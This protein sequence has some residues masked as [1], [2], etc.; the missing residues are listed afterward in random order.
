MR[1]KVL[2]RQ[3]SIILYGITPAYAGKSLAAVL[4]GFQYRDHPRLCG[5]KSAMKAYFDLAEGSPPPMRGKD[6]ITSALQIVC[7]ITPAYAGKS[8][9]VTK[10][11]TGDLGSPP[12]MRGKVNFLSQHQCF[13]QDHPR[14]CGEKCTQKSLILYVI[15]S[16]PP[17]RGKGPGAP[18]RLRPNRITPAYAGKS[19]GAAGGESPKQDHPRLCGEK[20]S[21]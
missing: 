6:I 11:P 4:Q 14:L 13:K 18:R 9:S 10:N 15:G 7:R 16:P 19:N 1:G 2:L 20:Q 3:K 5:E 21:I 8:S 17:M 12:P